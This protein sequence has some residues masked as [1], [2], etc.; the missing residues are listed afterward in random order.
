[1]TRGEDKKQLATKRNQLI[2]EIKGV[3]EELKQ[4]EAQL[5]AHSIRPHQIMAI[6]ELEEEIRRK[7][8]ELRNIEGRT[9]PSGNCEGNP[10]KGKGPLRSD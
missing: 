3:R 7:E 10:S 6:E 4:R 8:E 5:P 2:H 9:F 1:M